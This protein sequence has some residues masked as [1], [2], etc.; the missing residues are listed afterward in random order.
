MITQKWTG[1]RYLHVFSMTF[2]MFMLCDSV[3]TYKFV[4]MPF[5]Y[6]EACV[7]VIPFWFII[8]DI[9]AEVYG[10]KASRNILLSAF[11][12]EIVF[13][14]FSY[15]LVHLPSPS[16]WKNEFSYELIL[17]HLPRI[18]FSSALAVLI[19]GY[20]NIYFIVKWKKLLHGRYFW[21]R[22]IGASW[23]SEGVYSFIAVYFIL[24][25][26]VPF[27]AILIAILWSY[28]SKIILTIILSAPGAWIASITKKNE[29]I[30]SNQII[31]FNPLNGENSR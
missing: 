17:G 9:I 25:G 6:A 2:L 1:Y 26:V 4:A 18:I 15:F 31:S 13:A 27:H 11:A 28:L 10:Q 20:L 7:F 16:F 22:S 24:Y 23:I 8:G 30:P 19:S 5:G 14:F 3:F 21:L 12:I 29:C